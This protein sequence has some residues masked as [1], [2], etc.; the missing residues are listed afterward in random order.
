MTEKIAVIIQARFDS[1]R[2]P[3]KVM[4][5]VGGRPMLA[6]LIERIKDQNL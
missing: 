1:S 5:E 2:L 3:G 6:F 4:K